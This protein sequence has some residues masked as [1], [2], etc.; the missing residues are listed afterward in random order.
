MPQYS[1]A[2]CCASTMPCEPTAYVSSG[3]ATAARTEAV[4]AAR[5]VSWLAATSVKALACCAG[6]MTAASGAAAASTTAPR[7]ARERR[8]RAT[9]NMTASVIGVHAR[10][11]R[12]ARHFWTSG[13][14]R[15]APV[16]GYGE[17]KVRLRTGVD[18]AERRGDGVRR[19]R[20]AN[21]LQASL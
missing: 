7:A 16:W 9:E 14:C 4:D 19:A 1:R 20:R 11:L 18:G 15:P 10:S 21:R 6:S 2:I 5:A 3:W 17:L 8:V 13:R 12:R